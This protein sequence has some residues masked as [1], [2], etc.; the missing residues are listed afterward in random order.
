M[1]ALDKNKDGKLDKA[2]IAAASRVLAAMADAKGEI[3]A[4]KLRPKRPEGA[5]PG[6]RGGDREGG[7]EG[8]GRGRGGRPGA[9]R[10]GTERQGGPRNDRERG[11][12]R[13]E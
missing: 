12:Q 2:E 3:G 10:E 1:A 5:R 8:A 9:G 4:E 7:R 13:P 6:P 11:G